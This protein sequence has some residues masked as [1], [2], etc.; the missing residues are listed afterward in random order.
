LPREDPLASTRAEIYPKTQHEKL[1][2]ER[3]RTKLT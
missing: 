1:D 2:K 3:P